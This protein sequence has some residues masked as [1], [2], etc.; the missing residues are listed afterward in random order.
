MRKKNT[1]NKQLIVAPDIKLDL[2]AG[3]NPIPGFTS[4]DLYAPDSA[5]KCDL[6][7]LPWKDMAGKLLWSDNSV[8]EIHASHFVEHI[9]REKRWPFFEE[10]YRVLKPGGIMRIIVPSWKSERAIGDMT[11]EWP[12][13]SAMAFYYLSRNW[14]EANK[15]TYGPYD[16]K[17]DF[18]H[19]A[20]PTSISNAF[21]S[22]AHEVQV[23]ACTHYL[24]AYQ[25]MWTTLTKR[26]PED[27]AKA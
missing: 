2:G 4:V 23:F 1:R 14:R 6:F 7:K 24:E 10:C 19:A 16:I 12:P 8:S 11:H 9:P 27:H 13:V 5:V 20:G 18:D 26:A 3:R 21:T 17:C 15:L 25:D 22:K